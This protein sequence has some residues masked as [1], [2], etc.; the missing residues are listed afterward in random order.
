[1]VLTKEFQKIGTGTQKTYGQSAGYL[2]L[3][4]KYNSQ[5]IVNNRTNITVELRLVVPYGYIGNYQ[6]TNWEIG[7]SLSNSGNLGSGDYRSRTLG[8]ATG[9][10]T[11]ESDGKKDVS[12]TGSFDPTAW[13]Y[14]IDV[15]ATN[16]SLPTIPRAS[17]ILATS[18]YIGEISRIKVTQYSSQFTHSIQYSF[19]NLSGYILADGT[20]TNNE[21]KISALSIDFAI[22]S[23][24]FD[25]IPNEP[26]AECTLSIKTYKDNTQIG[27]TQTTVFYARV[28]ESSSNPVLTA[29]VL[30]TNQTTLALT[31]DSSILIKGHS[32]VSLT[33]SATARNSASIASVKVN[34]TTVTTS[35][36]VFILDSEDITIVATDTRGFTKTVTPSFTLKNYMPPNFSMRVIRVNPTSNSAYLSFEGT[37]FKESFGSVSNALSIAWKYKKTT[38]STWTNGGTLTAGTDYTVSNSNNNF[39]SGIVSSAADILIGNALDYNYGW[40]IALIVTD[41]LGSVAGYDSMPKGKPIINWEETFFNVNGDIRHNNVSIFSSIIDTFYPVGSIYMTV[42]STKDPNTMFSGTSW[43]QLKD[44]FLLGAG[45]TYT[46]GATGGA[47]TVTLNINQIPSHS[48]NVGGDKDA[49]YQYNGGDISLHDAGTSGA[50][51]LIA[52]SSSGGGQAHENMPPYL[53]V[54]MWKRVS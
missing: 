39:W 49:Q 47:A 52:T 9:N 12:F 2:E 53:V 38:D 3:W 18:A 13:G 45:D 42:D 48:H 24:W 6:A 46:N 32:I 51:R 36:Y 44:R 37:W 17:T 41:V 15:S 40:D 21:T 25:K 1:M 54:Y 20:T 43:T 4:A 8:S 14:S 10:I 35:P 28:N 16:I 31:G 27:E 30:D 50:G 5:D 29:S 33:W 11:H 22:P 19:K 7:G 26:E 34:G 23:S